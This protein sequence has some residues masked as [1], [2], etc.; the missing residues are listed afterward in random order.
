M[1]SVSRAQARAF[2]AAAAG[3][4]DLG[5]PRKV[6]EE[7]V[8]EDKGRNISALPERK[9][10]G[11]LVRKKAQTK[12]KLPTG[13]PTKKRDEA[14]AEIQGRIQRMSVKRLLRRIDPDDFEFERIE[15]KRRGRKRGRLHEVK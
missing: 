6:A 8:A 2:R 7:F 1:P 11:G 3:N 13:R 5:I 15:R 10:H 4:S 9:K 12:G 14:V